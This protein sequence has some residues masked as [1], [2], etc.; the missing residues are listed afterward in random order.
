[1]SRL[2][3]LL[4]TLASCFFPL[5]GVLAAENYPSKPITFVVP[6][7]AGGMTDVTARLLA[8]KMKESLGQP[9][10]V[11]NKPGGTGIVGVNYALSQKEDGYTVIVAP[12]NESLTS[13]YFQGVEPFDLKQF[14]FIGGYMPQARVLF[15]TPDKPYKNFAEF[16]EYARK[17]PGEVSVGSGGVQWALE[18]VKSIA[19]KENLKMKFVMFKSGGEAST[20]ILGGH[21]DTCETGVGTPAF[22]AGRQGKLLALVNMGEGKID[23]FPDLNDVKSL[24]Y[25]FAVT[26]EYGFAVKAGTPEPIRKKLEESLKAAMQ[27]PV[28]KEKFIEMGLIP[29]FT[30]GKSFAKIVQDSVAAVKAML[31][32]NKKLPQ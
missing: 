27:D 24:G 25:P 18:L 2:V 3:C 10:M 1:M 14:S 21:V 15:T 8:E 11:A 32:Y 26:I 23:A 7:G 22:Q 31:E 20:A 6:L 19:V 16:L 13:A 29:K 28:V 9:I 30:D 12:M 17:H 5:T 4:L